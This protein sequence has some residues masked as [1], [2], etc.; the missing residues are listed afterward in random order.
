MAPSSRILFNVARGLGRQV[1]GMHRHPVGAG[2]DEFRSVFVGIGDHEVHIEGDRRHF[3]HPLDDH[4]TDRDVGHE[5][6]VHDIDMNPVGAGRFDR[7]DLVFQ[8][9]E[10][11]RQY[12]RSD[13]HPLASKS[14]FSCARRK[15]RRCCPAGAALGNICRGPCGA[16]IQEDNPRPPANSNRLFRR[17][18]FS[19]IRSFSST[20]KVQVEYTRTPPTFKYWATRS[21]MRAWKAAQTAMSPLIALPFDLRVGAQSAKTAAWRVDEDA[22]VGRRCRNGRPRL[23]RLHWLVSMLVPSGQHS[24]RFSR[25]RGPKYRWRRLR[26][27][28]D[29]LGEMGALPPG[30]AHASRIRSPDAGRTS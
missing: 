19:T 7:L 3:A 18:K 23:R 24:A 27:D 10:V 28:R 30:A 4:R 20:V 11:G 8:P 14:P 2:F 16:P 13:F 1:S 21:T 12:R 25:R 15:T 5:M 9:A 17:K 22:I 6:A 29:Q 26:L